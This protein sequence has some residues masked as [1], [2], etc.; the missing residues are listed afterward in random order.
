MTRRRRRAQYH[1][2]VSD[3]TTGRIPHWERLYH[4]DSGGIVMAG[5]TLSRGRRDL[6]MGREI[7]IV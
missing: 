5:A 7:C 1:R 6:H 4:A 2:P 3:Q